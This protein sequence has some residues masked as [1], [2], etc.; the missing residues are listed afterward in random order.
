M[1][2]PEE[3]KVTFGTYTMVKGVEYWWENTFQCLEVEGQVVTWETFKWVF[4]E[5]YFPEDVRLLT[6]NVKFENL[7]ICPFN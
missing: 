4:Q 5:N 6:V 3:Q 1:A 7:K 2:C